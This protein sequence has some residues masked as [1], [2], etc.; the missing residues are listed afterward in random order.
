LLNSRDTRAFGI[1]DLGQVV[2]LNGD[3]G[4]AFLYDNGVVKELGALPGGSYSTAYEIN[5]Q[6]QIVGS[7]DN[8]EGSQAFIYSNGVMQNIGIP[9]VGGLQ[10][11]YGIDINNLGQV[12]VTSSDR[13]PYIYQNGILT[14][15]ND[16]IDPA[17]IDAGVTLTYVKG[18]N[19]R[20]QFITQGTISGK[21]RGFLLNPMQLVLVLK[22]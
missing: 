19:D 18:I 14:N 4:K 7:A 12:V 6:G 1:N 20:G 2:G 17:L 5:N 9:Y 11:R 22:T 15:L 16:L 13:K 10:S 3:T 8:S 21:K